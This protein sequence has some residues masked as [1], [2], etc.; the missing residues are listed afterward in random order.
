METVAEVRSGVAWLRAWADAGAAPS[1]PPP[2][3]A[4]P[5]EV[6]AVD[7]AAYAAFVSPAGRPVFSRLTEGEVLLGRSGAAV[8]AMRAGGGALTLTTTPLRVRGIVDDRLIGAHEAMVSTRTGETL[9]IVRPRYLLLQVSGSALRREV[10]SSLQALAP[11][12]M[13]LRVRGR[14]EA[15]TFRHGD[16]VLP[17]VFLKQMFGEFA[18]RR[19]SRGHLWPDAAWTEANIQTAHLPVVGAVRCHRRI[20]PQMR[21]AFEE[22][23]RAGLAHLVNPADFGGCFSPRFLGRDPEAGLSHH[24]WGVAFDL[25]VSE[26]LYGAR[27]RIDPRV[28]EVLEKWGF[29]WGG[30]WLIPDPMHFEFLE[31]PGAGRK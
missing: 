3:M 15:R 2:G 10:E 31:S 28:V 29:A 5:I 1:S 7:P 21:G 30:R 14:G 23:V 20:L 6:A 11:P 12:G 19:I 27:P 22:L 16:A 25:N 9:G 26:N 18:A 4:V 8:R 13:P 17:P 24:S